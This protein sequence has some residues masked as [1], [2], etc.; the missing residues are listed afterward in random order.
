M[1]FRFLVWSPVLPRE[2]IALAICKDIFICKEAV[3]VQDGSILLAAKWL[4]QNKNKS[5]TAPEAAGRIGGTSPFW[6]PVFHVLH[7]ETE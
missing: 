1:Q 3:K 2:H 5:S 7:L 4:H 6:L